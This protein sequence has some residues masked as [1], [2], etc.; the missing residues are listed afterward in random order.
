[1]GKLSFSSSEIVIK[2]YSTPFGA[3]R[4]LSISSNS[5][6]ALGGGGAVLVLGSL[7]VVLL[8]PFDSNAP[9]VLGDFDASDIVFSICED[10][11]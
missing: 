1:M 4:C 2:R 6:V 10:F 7:L 9:C 5:G 3:L 11:I 8:G